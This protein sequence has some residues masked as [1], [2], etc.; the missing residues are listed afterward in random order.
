MWDLLG[1]Q[2]RQAMVTVI[3]RE[4][5]LDTSTSL[6]DTGELQYLLWYKLKVELKRGLVSVLG[7]IKLR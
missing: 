6:D 1:P 5:S 7:T 2:K 4:L 3:K